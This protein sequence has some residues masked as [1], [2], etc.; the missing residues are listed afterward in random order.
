M[1]VDLKILKYKNEDEQGDVQRQ[2]D[3]IELELEGE[4][5]IT[6][7]SSSSSEERTF[8]TMTINVNNIVAI[9]PYGNNCLIHTIGGVWMAERSRSEAKKFIQKQIQ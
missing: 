4:T 2:D 8:A 9:Q 3:E 6:N 1:F 5:D 7:S